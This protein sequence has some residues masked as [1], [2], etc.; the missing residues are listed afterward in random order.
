MDLPALDFLRHIFPIGL[1]DQ[2][3]DQQYIRVTTLIP[4]KEVRVEATFWLTI[5]ELHTQN[6]EP[7]QL[8]FSNEQPL[9]GF[10]YTPHPYASPDSA[11]K[12]N[13]S[14]D[15]QTLYMDCDDEFLN[16]WTFDPKPSIIVNTSPRRYHVYWLLQEPIPTVEA[17][18]YNKALAYH[19]LTKDR[20]GWDRSQLLRV[21]DTTNHKRKPHRIR[22]LHEYSPLTRHTLDDFNQ[23]PPAPT[24]A[25]SL[26]LP[27]PD[28]A[29]LPLYDEVHE[30]FA[31]TWQKSLEAA[32]WKRAA[33]RSR[34]LWH[35]FHQSFRL[36]MDRDDVFV[37]A[38]KS[39]NNKWADCRYH[40]EDELWKDIGRA[41]KTLMEEE[42]AP[43]LQKLDDLIKSKLQTKQKREKMG[44]LI[45]RDMQA[46]GRFYYVE[47]TLASL[48]HTD[49]ELFDL[50][51]GKIRIEHLLMARYNLNA[52]TGE[53][54]H[55]L[56]YLRTRAP[57]IGEHISLRHLS[58]YDAET[59][60]LYV[61]DNDDGFWR[62]NGSA[63]P[64]ERLENGIDSI[65][66]FSNPL[67]ETRYTPRA[68]DYTGADEGFSLLDEIVFGRANFDTTQLPLEDSRF[69]VRA[70]TIALFFPSL[71]RTRPMLVLE[72]TKGSGK[73]M[74]FK[75]LSWLIEGPEGSVSQLPSDE[76]RFRELCRG[77]NYLFLDGVDQ[78]TRWLPNVLSTIA[79]GTE[80]RVRILY[81]NNDYA[82][83]R[84][85][86]MFGITTMDA[87]F[88]RDDVADRAIIL[89]A[90]PLKFHIP[91][92]HLHK[93]IEENRDFL[94][95]ELMNDLA[96]VTKELQNSQ[97]PD[98]DFRMAD[99]AHLLFA[100]CRVHDRE[101]KHLI[102]FMKQRQTQAVIEHDTFWQVMEM[103][104]EGG[105]DENPNLGRMM[106]PGHLHRELLRLGNLNE[107]NYGKFIKS[108]TALGRKL[109]QMEGAFVAQ[110]FEMR[111]KEDIHHGSTKY[112][113]FEEEGE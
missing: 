72:G 21:P 9:R 87:K 37:V 49:K 44:E 86:V 41:E 22:V 76:D 40:A 27:T 70:W 3:T 94:W 109:R 103:W 107:I 4:G 50:G 61:A 35:L 77:R 45:L 23:I 60:Y 75:T 65:F 84:L 106:A 62:M 71:M 8:D 46:R 79:T 90:T 17:E 101:P 11:Q 56:T 73:T 43:I 2:H 64:Q 20:S 108:A 80:E 10:F 83:Y 53:F 66:F 110:G 39:V 55:I 78:S 42:E 68:F 31:E 13:A 1:N 112:T 104:L 92:F 51:R 67:R 16:P 15:T 18:R 30:K 102:R 54:H 88:M 12:D 74:L 58:H 82:S 81:T 36:G 113:F 57:E 14:L 38:L 25:A 89:T 96:A 26:Q 63:E 100:L 93:E 32:V 33:D 29:A 19:Y 7:P 111:I 6:E 98:E 59:G 97:S 105:G 85:A 48:Y 34:A 69:L 91:E 24:G 5:D 47:A 28:P 52:A 99:F 95:W